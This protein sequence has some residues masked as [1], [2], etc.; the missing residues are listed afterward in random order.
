MTVAGNSLLGLLM[1]MLRITGLLASSQVLGGGLVPWR[2]RIALALAT[3]LLLAPVVPPAAPFFGAGDLILAG[4][5]ELL[6]GLAVGLTASLFIHGVRMAGQVAG[7][8]MGLG[9]SA[10][11]DPQSGERTTVLARWLG[12]TAWLV[13]LGCNG[14][15]V[16]LRGLAES[17]SWLPPGSA[18]RSL[19]RVVAGVPMAG[20]QLFL[21][22][23]VVAAPALAVVLL[24]NVGMALL[25]RA[26]PQLHILVI[27][28]IITIV[29]GVT[30]LAFSLGGLAGQFRD[31][32]LRL[33]NLALDLC[34]PA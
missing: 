15:L 21:T 17:F 11:V 18:S 3:S 28:F 22:A 32:Y 29:V 8:Q 34:K 6:L 27:G 31:G 23:V 26:A 2:V 1:V 7:I 9:F 14:H 30:T 12:L 4:A 25:A 5:A 10:L 20:A 19:A 16:L 24:L 33:A 13:V